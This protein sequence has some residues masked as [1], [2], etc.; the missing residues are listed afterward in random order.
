MAETK[1]QLGLSVVL[2]GHF[3]LKKLLNWGMTFMNYTGN[4]F[5]MTAICSMAQT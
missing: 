2:E 1:Q 4:S 5:M 3:S